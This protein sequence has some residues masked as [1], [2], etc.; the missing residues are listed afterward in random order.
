MSKA[1]K[2]Y[3]DGE[4][5]E[6]FTSKFPH[7]D[8]RKYLLRYLSYLQMSQIRDHYVL[9]Q[10]S[11]ERLQKKYL[12]RMLLQTHLCESKPNKKRVIMENSAKKQ[13]L[14]KL[15]HRLMYK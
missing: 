5:D 13:L 2:L 10:K 14:L 7:W 3:L 12:Y 8:R 1:L 9:Q 11:Q 15:Y 6:L 4:E